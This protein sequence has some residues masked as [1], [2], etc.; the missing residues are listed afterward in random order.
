MGKVKQTSD[1]TCAKL[2]IMKKVVIS[3]SSTKKFPFAKKFTVTEEESFVNK[4]DV[5]LKLGV[6]IV[7]TPKSRFS[8]TVSFD[9]DLSGLTLW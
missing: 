2:R 5:V 7:A 3:A 8:G 6:P 4:N 9:D 1:S